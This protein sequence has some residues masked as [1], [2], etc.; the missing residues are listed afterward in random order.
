MGAPVNPTLWKLI[1]GF[2]DR[3]K[4]AREALGIGQAEFARSLG[5]DPTRYNHW[6]K[7][8]H[9]PN[10]YHLAAIKKKHGIGSDWILSGDYR[11][12]PSEVRD[13]LLSQPAA[14]PPPSKARPPPRPPVGG[15]VVGENEIDQG[16]RKVVRL[17]RMQA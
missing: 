2:G 14:T 1:E 6:E 13:Q 4:S 12:L 5:V 16:C 15:S 8:R 11:A 3:L 9:P 7:N 17:P 10:V